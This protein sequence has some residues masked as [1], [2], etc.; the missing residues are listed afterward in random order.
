MPHI[1][2]MTRNQQKNCKIVSMLRVCRKI[3]ICVFL[4]F[5]V[6]SVNAMALTQQ[7]ISFVKDSAIELCR[8]GNIKGDAKNYR[9]E[10]DAEFKTIIIK[11]I[12]EAGVGGKIELSGEEW[13]GIRAVIPDQWDA[14]SWNQCDTYSRIPFG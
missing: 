9:I 3:G 12:F 11:K 6:L 4:F 8:G 5:I 2:K 1:A 13:N 7:E 14:S 10:G